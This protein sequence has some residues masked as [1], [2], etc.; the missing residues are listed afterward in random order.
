MCNI[1]IRTALIST[2]RHVTRWP[3]HSAFLPPR[4]YTPGN[5]HTKIRLSYD[6]PRETPCHYTS[7]HPIN[8][9]HPSPAKFIRLLIRT[10]MLAFILTPK[11]ITHHTHMQLHTI[12]PLFTQVPYI[13]NR[14]SLIRPPIL[15]TLQ[16]YIRTSTYLTLYTFHSISPFLRTPKDLALLS[17]EVIYEHP[18]KHYVTIH[19]SPT[20]L[21]HHTHMPLHTT[22][23]QYTQVPGIS[24]QRSFIRTPMHLS[25]CHL[26]LPCRHCA[27]KPPCRRSTTLPPCRRAAAGPL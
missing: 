26:P 12:I 9:W 23:W 7:V 15:N 8:N 2:C 11:H 27:T 20:H 4:H 19:P 17:K 14:R 25:P 6:H 16:P 22:I 3:S 13:S 1:S 24:Q 10:T 5:T 18:L 21:T